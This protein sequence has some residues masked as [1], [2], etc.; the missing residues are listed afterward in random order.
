MPIYGH[1]QDGHFDYIGAVRL[2]YNVR[3]EKI[4]NISYLWRK[5]VA[6][7]LSNIENPPSGMLKFYYF[8]KLPT[9]SGFKFKKKKM[10]KNKK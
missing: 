3:D 2:T 9:I 1:F 5:K 6:N 10:E 8:F 7:F 4:G